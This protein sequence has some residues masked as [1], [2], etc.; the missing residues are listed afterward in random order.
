MI[1]YHY[2]HCTTNIKEP[3]RCKNKQWLDQQKKPDVIT[4]SPDGK[5]ELINVGG[6]QTDCSVCAIFCPCSHS[7]PKKQ[8]TPETIGFRGLQT[9]RILSL[10]QVLPRC[11]QRIRSLLLVTR[12]LR[13][14]SR[15]ILYELR[16]GIS[17]KLFLSLYIHL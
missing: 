3:S 1:L 4:T 12:W 11:F 9:S 5:M 16:K 8:Q 6:A 15:M 7:L 17:F 14:Q 2:F 13:K 10:C